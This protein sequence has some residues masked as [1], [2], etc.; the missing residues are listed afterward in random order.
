MLGSELCGSSSWGDSLGKMGPRVQPR[1][2][3]FNESRIIP[4]LSATIALIIII[5]IIII[6]AENTPQ[7]LCT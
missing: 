6:I 1:A 7:T 5:I 4:E 3:I 2:V